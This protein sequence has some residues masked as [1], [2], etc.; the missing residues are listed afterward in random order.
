[1][2]ENVE[3]IGDYVFEKCNNLRTVIIDKNLKHIGGYSL[4]DFRITVYYYGSEED[5]AE[6]EVEPGNAAVDFENY[7]SV[8]KFIFNYNP[9]D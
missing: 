5:W 2:P 6:V 4:N 1:M 8:I 9:N 3:E 7:S